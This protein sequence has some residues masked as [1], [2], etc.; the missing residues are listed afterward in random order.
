[1]QDSRKRRLSLGKTAVSAQPRLC[2]RC[3]VPWLFM[4]ILER[5]AVSKHSP[6]CASFRDIRASKKLAMGD[7]CPKA[8]SGPSSSTICQR[9]VGF[10]RLDSS[11]SEFIPG[12][13]VN[14]RGG[15]SARSVPGR[16]C[17]RFRLVPRES[18]R[19]CE[20]TIG[21]P[22]HK[23]DPNARQPCDRQLHARKPAGKRIRATGAS[24]PAHL[25]N[26]QQLR[27]VPPA[28]AADALRRGQSHC[29][30]QVGQVTWIVPEAPGMP[31]FRPHFGQSS[32]IVSL[33][34]CGQKHRTKATPGRQSQASIAGCTGGIS[35]L[36]NLLLPRRERMAIFFDDGTNSHP[37]FRVA[38]HAGHCPARARVQGLFHHRALRHARGAKSPR[39]NPAASFCPAARPAFMRPRR[40]CR[41]RPFSIWAFPSWAF[42][43]ACN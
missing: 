43:T 39:S 18:C 16:N 20:S 36:G 22:Q 30:L 19:S 28:C 7:Y 37:G 40:R 34:G 17:R 29:S 26:R 23:S 10:E 35:L 33:I 42:V 13:F 14:T 32:R 27:C 3:R 25:E 4:R 31:I 5:R 41:T 1:M 9:P 38:I 8:S 21:F 15:R 2:R 12:G 24:D 11:I 6:D